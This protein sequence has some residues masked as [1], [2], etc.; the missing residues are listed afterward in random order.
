MWRNGKCVRILRD[1]RSDRKYLMKRLVRLKMRE[2]MGAYTHGRLTYFRRNF[3]RVVPLG[4][5]F[6]IWLRE[7]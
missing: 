2:G 7:L 6:L 1:S 4:P 3:K 5:A